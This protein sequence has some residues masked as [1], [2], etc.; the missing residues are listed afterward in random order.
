MGGLDDV[1]PFDT[2]TLVP[3]THHLQRYISRSSGWRP[4][5]AHLEFCLDLVRLQHGH[6]VPCRDGF[7]GTH[8]WRTISLGIRVL[9]TEPSEAIELLRWMDV[10]SIL[11][12]WHCIGTLPRRYIDPVLRYRHVSRLRAY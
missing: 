8:C 4:S 11:A 6:V 7:N 5:R 3:R 10:N 2:H 12:G 9:S 1:S